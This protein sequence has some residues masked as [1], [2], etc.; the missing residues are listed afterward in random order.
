MQLD[1]RPEDVFKN[2]SSVNSFQEIL[3]SQQHRK[4]DNMGLQTMTFSKSNDSEYEKDMKLAFTFESEISQLTDE[5][6]GK[7]GLCIQ[8][9]R[10]AA[11]HSAASSQNTISPSIADLSMKIT[12]VKKVWENA[13]AMPTVLE[14][15]NG[16]NVGPDDSHMNSNFVTSHQQHMHQF[17][18]AHANMSHVQH[19]LSPAPCTYA[20]SFGNDNNSLDQFSKVG[21][22]GDDGYNSGQHNHPGGHNAH[23]NAAMKHAAEAL[24][25][26]PN[27]CKVKPT[28][29]Q[30]HQSSLGLSPPPIQAGGLQAAPQPYYQASQ[31]GGM[32]AIPSPPAVLYNS[33]PMPS[34]GGLYGHFQI[35]ASRSQFSQ[36]PPYGAGNT[37]YN[38]YMQTPPNLQTAPAPD[39]YQS[40][41]SQFRMG[42]AVQP[43]FNQTQQHNPSTVLISSTS[44][45]LMSASVKP[46]SQQ[47][48]A[49]GSKSGAVSQSPYGGQYMGMYAPQQGPPP[50]PPQMQ[51]N[52]YYSNSAGQGAFFGAPANAGTQSFGLQ[53]NTGGMFSGHGGPQAPP[54][55][56]APPPATGFN[57]QFLSMA[58][59]R[60]Y[61]G[62]PSP[63]NA[64]AY[65]KNNQPQQQGQSQ[66]PNQPSHQDSVSSNS[67]FK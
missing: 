42:G 24:A 61:Q 22:D 11:I 51:N 30:L 59:N 29:Q 7:G 47:I 64:N 13:P 41:T 57:S 39:M 3:D 8:P 45:S 52:S 16:N 50:P 49:I 14:N 54:P 67:F 55:S 46:S 66:Q 2:A 35:E 15:N 1:K 20:G 27:V 38:A 19:T 33:S 9:A 48:G 56:N 26:S 58:M 36:Y 65:M 21:Q 18:H 60:Q 31:F 23:Q 28:Q 34:Q 62:G 32:S 40:L 10:S 37:P 44:N 63:Q 4:D 6:N 17:N 5:K 12:S 25:T 43:P 53:A